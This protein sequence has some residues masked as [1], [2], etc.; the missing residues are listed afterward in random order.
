MAGLTSEKNRVE[1]AVSPETLQRMSFFTGGNLDE[2]RNVTLI[3]TFQGKQYMIDID[4]KG[5][6]SVKQQS[7]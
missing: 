5:H 1:Q 2:L 6:A 7:Q 3:V 4:S